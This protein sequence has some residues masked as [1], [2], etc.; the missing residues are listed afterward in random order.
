[1][2]DQLLGQKQACA[3]AC[4]DF[5]RRPSFAILFSGGMESEL[6][7][8]VLCWSASNLIWYYCSIPDA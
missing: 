6:V 5:L 8:D 3:C 4:S 7:R 1:M 2:G